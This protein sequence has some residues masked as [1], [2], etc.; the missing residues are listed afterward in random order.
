MKKKKQEMISKMKAKQQ[1]FLQ[2]VSSE[3][4]QDD[5]MTEELKHDG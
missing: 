1:Q 4:K 2:K 3:Q 5:A